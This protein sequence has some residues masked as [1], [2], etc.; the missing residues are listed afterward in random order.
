[1][2]GALDPAALRALA[3]QLEAAG[4]ANGLRPLPALQGTAASHFANM[5]MPTPAPTHAPQPSLMPG[6]GNQLQVL[7]G[8]EFER[9]F[10][11]KMAPIIEQANQIA[12]Q[13]QQASTGGEAIKAGMMQLI[14]ASASPD[15]MAFVNDHIAKGAPGFREFLQSETI[16]SWVQLGIEEYKAF[17]AGSKK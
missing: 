8:Q 16:R 10:N 9:L 3:T 14:Q 7:I 12:Q 15:D 6:N 11:A 2:T 17:L 1:M 5:F 4:G 13:A